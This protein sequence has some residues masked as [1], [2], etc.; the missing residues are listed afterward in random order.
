MATIT[1]Q[2]ERPATLIDNTTDDPT[3]R[4]PDIG[5]AG[6]LLGW[7]PAV[8]LQDGLERTVAHFRT[9]RD[10]GRLVSARTV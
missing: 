4:R 10:S 1:T 2:P 6:E 7:V 5:L 8:E 9:M 3:R